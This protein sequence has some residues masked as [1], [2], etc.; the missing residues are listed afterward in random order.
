MPFA[1][2]GASLITRHLLQAIYE[3]LTAVPELFNV[4][5]GLGRTSC[6]TV[7]DHGLTGRGVAASCGEQATRGGTA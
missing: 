4:L 3:L 1:S 5:D 6:A 7:P 2:L